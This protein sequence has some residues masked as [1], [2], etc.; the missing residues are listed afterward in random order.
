[1]ADGEYN[2]FGQIFTKVLDISKYQDNNA[3]PERPDFRKARAKGT[4]AVV[5][6]IS[7]NNGVDEDAE[8]NWKAVQD[9]DMIPMA[10]HWFEYRSGIM[11]NGAEQGK[12]CLDV[13]DMINGSVENVPIWLDY[14]QP[15][16]AW[17]PLPNY[18]TS[19]ANLSR[20][21]EVTDPA[22]KRLTGLYGNRVTIAN[23]TPVPTR[24][25]S[26]PFWPAGWIFSRIM[27][28]E[29]IIGLSWRP[30]I[31][32][33]NKFVLWQ[34]GLTYG[35]EYGMETAE[36]DLNFFNGTVE[37]LFE[38]TGYKIPVEPTQPPIELTIQEQIDQIKIDIEKLKQEMIDH[39][40][41][42]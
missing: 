39:G 1:M 13:L 32:P 14:E 9:A 18:Y 30:N 4:R 26:R 21:F 35:Y 12:T 42:V 7:A 33:W 11:V 10:Y 38:F 25:L 28:A 22:T 29:E 37:Q 19:I 6:R 27:R 8:Y 5:I 24:T 15:N 41:D 34:C 17:P 20:F 23:I 3:T 36:V 31:S 16:A 2:S 40:W